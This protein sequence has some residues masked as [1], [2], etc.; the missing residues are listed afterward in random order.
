M[1]L[2]R[3][4]P[5]T[6]EQRQAMNRDYIGLLKLSANVYYIQDRQPRQAAFSG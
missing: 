3:K 4:F 6:D 1:K 5:M 2:S